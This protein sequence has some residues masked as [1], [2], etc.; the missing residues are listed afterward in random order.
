MKR[1]SG[2][3]L[4]LGVALKGDFDKE[5]AAGRERVE[6]ALFAAV[7]GFADETKDKWRQDVAS[8][9]LARA[10]FLSKTIRNRKYP[11]KGLNP[12]GLIYSTFPILQQAFE[13]GA[14]VRS[15]QGFFLP[16]PNPAV[17]PT[18]RVPKGRR[19]AGRTNTIAVAERRFGP[20]RFVYRGNGKPSL[21][22]AEVRTSNT[23]GRLAKATDRQ[24][25][26]GTGLTTI[27]VFFLVKQARLP[28]LLRGAEIRRRAER[29]ATGRVGQL[30]VRY[31]ESDTG[32]PRLLTTGS[33]E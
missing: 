4:Q 5:V 30:F 6:R 20:L 32:A 26:R 8:S 15:Q 22:V 31:F 11:N 2:L 23:T 14:V 7:G 17:W 10:G 3:G 16:I 19:G 21:L 9:R 29:D 24:R 12:A 28:R 13:A 33:N 18:G 25:T 27:I 1:S